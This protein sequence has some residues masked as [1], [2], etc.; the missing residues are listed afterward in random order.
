MWI[1]GYKIKGKAEFNQ[2]ILGF[3]V[4]NSIFQVWN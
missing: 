3:L 2:Q 1:R 4:E